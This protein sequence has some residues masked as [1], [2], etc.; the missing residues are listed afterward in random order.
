MNGESRIPATSPT[1]PVAGEART[2]PADDRHSPGLR[3]DEIRGGETA[4]T[5]AATEQSPATTGEAELILTTRG[6][7]NV[8]QPPAMLHGEPQDSAVAQTETAWAVE[9]SARRASK[10]KTADEVAK[11]TD[12]VVKT[13]DEEPAAQG[14][15]LLLPV[16]SFVRGSSARRDTPARA[17]QVFPEEGST[18][19]AGDRARMS[20]GG[21]KPA[22]ASAEPAAG[23]APFTLEAHVEHLRA[24]MQTARAEAPDEEGGT[25]AVRPPSAVASQSTK[26]LT[27][28][29]RP[30]REPPR[31]APRAEFEGRPETPTPAPNSGERQPA[32]LV[33][34]ELTGASSNLV[35]SAAVARP[36]TSRAAWAQRGGLSP[37]RL[38]SEETTPAQSAHVR[39]AGASSDTQDSAPTVATAFAPVTPIAPVPSSEGAGAAS[40]VGGRAPKLTINRLD[41]QVVGRR[42][43]PPEPPP[44][45]TPASESPPRADPW[46]ALDRQ[47]LGRFSY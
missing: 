46:G 27:T 36:A 21:A 40:A 22:E 1:A 45:E 12:E 31:A 43:P 47:H 39:T 16:V 44:H 9:G 26:P 32:V 33:N 13:A 7:F 8:G 20:E 35:T 34:Q 3:A 17:S 4:R 18:T 5:N 19:S 41:V 37:A 42:E 24:L 25:D 15:S 2:H 10:A 38:R 28:P 14:A 29:A 11:T 6:H 30:T 23:S